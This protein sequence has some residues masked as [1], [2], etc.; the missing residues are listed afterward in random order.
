MK[1]FLI[2]FILSLLSLTCTYA[3]APFP[4]TIVLVQTDVCPVM[5]GKVNESVGVITDGKLYYF[6]CPGCIQMF[7]NDFDKYSPKLKDAKEVVLTVT[8]KNGLC[9]VTG[10]KASLE[11]FKVK[12]KNITFYH[13]KESIE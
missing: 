4:E 12:G 6:C 10:K 13:D 2:V 3:E 8:N 9:P 11:F 1:K 7:L 5:G